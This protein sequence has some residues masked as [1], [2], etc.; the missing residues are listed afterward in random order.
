VGTSGPVLREKILSKE[1]LL[2]VVVKVLRVSLRLG[3][4]FT[5]DG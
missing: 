3:A 1:I 4:V 2:A 5:R